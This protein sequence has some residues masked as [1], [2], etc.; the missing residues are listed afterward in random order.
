MPRHL[1]FCIVI[2]ATLITFCSP[3][4]AVVD[5]LEGTIFRHFFGSSSGETVSIVPAGSS[6]SSSSS[7]WPSSSSGTTTGFTAITPSSDSRLIYV[8]SS[9][10]S[11]SNDCLS[12][13]NPCES[14]TAA[15]AK[16][17][18]GFPDHVYFKRGDTWLNPSFGTVRSGRSESEP[19]VIASYGPSAERPLL[20]FSTNIVVNSEGAQALSSPSYDWFH[21]SIIGLHFRAYRMDPSDP[22]YFEPDSPSLFLM[23]E[24]ENIL[25]ED[26]KFTH[27]ELMVQASGT[28]GSPV[29]IKFRRNILNGGYDENTS[30]SDSN[31]PSN[32]YAAGVDG[33]LIEENV[34]DFGGWN[35]VTPDA[36]ANTFNHNVYLQTSNVGNKVIFRRNIVS[37]GSA[38]GVHGRAGGVFENNFYARNAIGQQVGFKNNP[39]PAGRIATMKDNVVME[40]WS[41][42]SKGV[43][44]CGGGESSGLLCTNAVWAYNVDDPGDG[45]VNVINNIACNAPIAGELGT[46]LIIRAFHSDTNEHASVNYEGNIAYNW[47]GGYSGTGVT[48]GGSYPDP[49]RSLG[50]YNQSIGGANS[51]DAFMDAV[52]NRPSGVWYEN[53]SAPAI[54]DY[55]RA[56]FNKPAVGN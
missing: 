14:H 56:G 8:S 52:K 51:Y 42:H 12:P 53:Q 30:L 38:L 37:R 4:F 41:V 10:G 48:V 47:S 25:I 31:K 24:L 5:I 22:D 20:N 2:F 19:A 40:G 18:N 45:D 17:R 44:P 28:D 13:E 3:A 32:I 50:K 7:G 34:L 6:S 1:K 16:M 39:F 54:N 23:G 27:V 9:E 55:V 11:D 29:N 21:V 33:L 36:G 46:S 43:T 49:C 26:N 15:F 35:P